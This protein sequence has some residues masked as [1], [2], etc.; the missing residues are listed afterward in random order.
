MP[1]EK[2]RNDM[3]DWMSGE[4]VCCVCGCPENNTREQLSW[5]ALGIDFDVEQ[6]M[7]DTYFCKHMPGSLGDWM[8]RKTACNIVP[9]AVPG[10]CR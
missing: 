8:S 5:V 10:F 9:E 7:T 3:W 2:A 4:Q 1:R 6:K